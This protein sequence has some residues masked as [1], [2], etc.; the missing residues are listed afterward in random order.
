MNKSTVSIKIIQKLCNKHNLSLSTAESCSGG[1]LSKLMTDTSGSSKFYNGSIIAY[2][3]KVKTDIL[4]VP[5]DVLVKNGAVSREVSILM[6]EGVLNLID[7]DIAVSTTGIMEQSKQD[8]NKAPQVY[9]TVKSHKHQSVIHLNVYMISLINIT[10][11]HKACNPNPG[12]IW[13]K[14]HKKH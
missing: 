14:I 6:A 9:I 1:Y 10:W 2:T 5:N 8:D 11:Y 7:C 3:N 4:K 12:K 13:K